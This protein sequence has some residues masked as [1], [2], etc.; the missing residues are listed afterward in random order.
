MFLELFLLLPHRHL[1][2][3]CC[4]VTPA[5][6][7]QKRREGEVTISA[8]IV[9]TELA[10]RSPHTTLE[11]HPTNT[12]HTWSTSSNSTLPP[13]S[14]K[15]QIK[16]SDKVSVLTAMIDSW[17]AGNFLDRTTTKELKIPFRLLNNIPCISGIDGGSIGKGT[18]TARSQ[19]CYTPVVY[20]QKFISFLITHSPDLPWYSLV[21]PSWP[22]HL[23]EWMGDNKKVRAL[24]CQPTKRNTNYSCIFQAQRLKSSTTFQ[25]SARTTPMCS[26]KPKSRVSYHIDPL[27]GTMPPRSH[28]Y[29]LSITTTKENKDPCRITFRKLSNKDRLFCPPSSS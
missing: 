1:V 3:S 7:L 5:I 4:W 18:I 16:H 17:S 20:T 2:N 25:R 19:S 24:S 26:A 9:V 13:F 21:K 10:T 6:L 29:S 27:P 15:V 22:I 23:M 8:S 28:I 14:L 11:A 12:I